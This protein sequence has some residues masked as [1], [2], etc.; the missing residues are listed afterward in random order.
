MYEVT[1]IRGKE[2][3][4]LSARPGQNLFRLFQEN[5]VSVWAPCGGR[6]VCGK[7][8][9][10]LDP[11]PDPGQ[12]R[13]FLSRRE[14]DEGVRLCCKTAVWQNMT[15]EICEG[16]AHVEVETEAGIGRLSPSVRAERR[17]FSPPSL[18]DQTDFADRSGFEKI[19]PR[20]LS[21]LAEAMR[22]KT[23]AAM[24]V[25]RDGTVF[26]PAEGGLYGMAL[27]IGTTTLAAYL[28]DL[29]S[30]R[31]LGVRSAVN[32]QRVFG[33][34]VISRMD[35]ARTPQG[36]K[37][38]SDCIRQGVNRLIE[39]FREDFGI[40]EV[41]HLTVTGNTTMLHLLAAVRP[42][43]MAQSPF[44]PVF[45][46]T[47]EAEGGQW[48]LN[49]GYVTL[50]PSLSAYGG[51]DVLGGARA[52]EVDRKKDLTLYLDVGTNGEML[53]GRSGRF[54]GC[55]TAAGPAFE[56]ANI[57]CGMPAMEGAVTAFRAE[58]GEL[59]AEVL[60]GGEPKGLCGSGLLDAVAVL[61]ELGVIDPSGA[62]AEEEDL[63]D[64]LRSRFTSAVLPDG[65]QVTGFR[66]CGE[67]VL[68]QTDI[69][70][71]QLAKAAVAA[72]IYTLLKELD[73]RPEEIGEVLIAG[74]FGNYLDPASAAAVG[75]IP[76]NLRDRV[77][78]VGNASG[79]AA[80]LALCDRAF[81]TRV[82]NFKKQVKN[83]ELSGSALFNEFY[84]NCLLF[85]GE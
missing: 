71:L 38:L 69:R 36:L 3:R 53:L 63:P 6:G 49:A 55:A 39:G 81:L 26:A 52:S 80:C 46:R 84:M 20:A 72:G 82:E 66:L 78:G 22:G 41:A 33:Q 79:A 77:R 43:T 18:E 13:G 37:E 73:A 17:H 59:C 44:I 28:F 4:T 51:A 1:L 11:A 70:E 9:V 8:K 40:A 74:G 5:G 23:E 27:D 10:R 25:F 58:G 32:T 30:G 76:P 75:M 48:G 29:E 31:R 7:C 45:T 16:E 64:P 61:L 68:L 21:A 15:A 47:L 54:L 50:L 14:L 57:S 35:H 34:D 42:D 83:V 85:E 62:F 65:R 56:G 60:G 24:A 19:S 67:V 12:S 2:R